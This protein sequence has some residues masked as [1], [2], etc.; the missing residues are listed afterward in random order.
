[1]VLQSNIVMVD[2]WQHFSLL[3]AARLTAVNQ[4]HKA[5]PTCTCGLSEESCAQ[6]RENTILWVGEQI[7]AH[8]S[9]INVKLKYS[10]VCCCFLRKRPVTK[11]QTFPC[12]PSSF[13]LR[14]I[15]A[16]SLQLRNCLI[17]FDKG[18]Y[19]LLVA[20]L[21]LE[22]CREAEIKIWNVYK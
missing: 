22:S 6:P 3:L 10:E 20:A 4:H 2:E 8:L 1:M 14:I 19:P 7:Y 21:V 17:A 16:V 11:T 12:R 9:I 13:I 18:C 5:P 15:Q